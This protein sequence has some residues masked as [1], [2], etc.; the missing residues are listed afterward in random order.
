[1][2]AAAGAAADVIAECQQKE[3]PP[4]GLSDGSKRQAQ[5]TIQ[6]AGREA[7]QDSEG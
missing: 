7:S 6:Q 1:M 3:N 4:G 2:G 5:K